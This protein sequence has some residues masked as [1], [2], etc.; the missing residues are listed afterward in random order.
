[1]VGVVLVSSLLVISAPRV[2]P[3][4]EDWDAPAELRTADEIRGREFA[5]SSELNAFL[6]SRACRWRVGSYDE[7]GGTLRTDQALGLVSTLDSGASEGA[8]P[9]VLVE[10]IP[11]R[12]TVGGRPD[13][14][15]IAEE[16]GLLVGAIEEGQALW[17]CLRDKSQ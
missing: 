11:V 3:L 10:A 2:I 14:W 5:T 15:A 8:E 1:M 9:W 16:N 12:H 6:D 17:L 13:L 4:W 7:G